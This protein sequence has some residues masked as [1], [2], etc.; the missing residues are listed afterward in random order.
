[1]LR[2]LT[3]LQ[4]P[5]PFVENLPHRFRHSDFLSY[6]ASPV[7]QEEASSGQGSAAQWDRTSHENGE[8]P[9]T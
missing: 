8:G 3:T 5:P 2:F 1:M 9:D 4:I 6:G 7:G